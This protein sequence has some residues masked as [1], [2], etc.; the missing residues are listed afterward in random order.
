MLGTE[1]AL[2]HFNADGSLRWQ[3]AVPGPVW[4]VNLPTDGAQAGQIVVA[5]YGDGTLRWHRLRDGAELLAFFPH[6]DRQRWV[7]WTPSGY[8][9]ASPGA[10]DLIGWHVN[11]G[12]DQAADFYPASRFR[13]RFYRPDIIDRVLDTLDEAQAVAQA[14]AA[15]D[16]REATVRVDQVLPPVVDLLAAPQRFADTQVPIRIRV[17]TPADAPATRLRVLVNHQIQPA[18]RAARPMTSDGGQELDL[19]LPPQDSEVQILADN[20]HG[21]SVPLTL[22]LQWAGDRKVFDLGQQGQRAASKPRL[23]VLAVGVSQ[24]QDTAV[25]PLAFAHLDAQA[26]AQTLAGQQGKAYSAVHTRVLLDAQASRQAVLDGLD[27]LQRSVAEGDVGIVFLAG[28]GFTMATDHRYYF[29]SHDVQLARLTDTGVPYSA[30]QEAMVAF[31]LRGGGTRAVFFIDTCHAGD[32]SGARL[33]GNVKT[34]NADQLAAELSRQ[35]N[36]VLVF[37]SSRGDQFSLEDP[38]L[39]HGVFTKALLE[40]L[41]EE[42][43]A[44]AF[45]LGAVTYKGLDA[46]VSVR[47]PV[48]SSRR[49]TPRLLAPPGGV[50]DFALATK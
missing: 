23:W 48:L 50:D 36:Q 3:H 37:A 47:V 1:W 45:G 12:P 14:N 10:E 22:R 9:D 17:R 2:R 40:G 39:G 42:W 43:R 20:R 15:A 21:S 38:R 4:G 8:Y 30:I 11:R 5:A 18:S 35:E 24:Y 7:L 49:Q 16:R 26:F 28:H 6:A 34:S 19:T 41:G 33:L 25:R 31:N 27:W 46:W 44:D 13:E 29:G 32:A